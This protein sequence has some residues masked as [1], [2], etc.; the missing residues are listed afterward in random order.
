MRQALIDAIRTEY[1][2]APVQASAPIAAGYLSQNW[3]LVTAAGTYFLKRYHVDQR[4]AVAAVHSVISHFQQANFPVV[5]PCTT[6]EGATI[7]TVDGG[8]YTLFPFVRGHQLQRGALTS[9]AVRTLG[10]ML[11]RLHRA[12]CGVQLPNVRV[13][14]FADQRAAFQHRAEALL[15]IIDGQSTPTPFDELARETV[16]LQLALVAQT[17]FDPAA[18]ALPNDH[19]LHGDYH[20]DNLFFDEV[21]SI[22]WI[23]D[24]ER[25]AV[26]A[27]ASELM[28]ALIFA[29]FATPRDFQ[30][31]FTPQN[32]ALGKDFLDAYQRHYPIEPA[33]A[34][35][36]LQARY[37][38]S[39]SSLWVV[40]EHYLH[41]NQRV[42]PFL[43]SN[44]SEVTYF[45]THLPQLIDWLDKRLR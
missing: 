30:A 20:V 35:A 33:E 22:R 24:W 9:Q 29:C 28:R 12:G 43:A 23:F 32:F 15:P 38:D 44:F 1:G 2:L 39:L 31:T 11:A 17:P 16:R 3:Q 19:L 45:S 5:A 40:E 4:T 6:R 36:A 18:V 42:D 7:C 14:A 21:G 37:W 13:R 27:R 34:V 10:A 8:H 25:A 41:H 26:G